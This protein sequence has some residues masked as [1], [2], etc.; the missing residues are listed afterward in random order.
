MRENLCEHYVLL[1]SFCTLNGFIYHNL[2]Q[3][4]EGNI[5]HHYLAMFENSEDI[6]P[7]EKGESII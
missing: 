6:M 1:N 2:R 7:Y 3:I 5:Q 4:L